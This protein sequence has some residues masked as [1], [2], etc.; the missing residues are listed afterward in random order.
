MVSHLIAV[1]IVS[2]AATLA[3]FLLQRLFANRVPGYAFPVA[4]GLTAISYNLWAEYTWYARTKAAL[5]DTVEVVQTYQVSSALTP[6]TVLMP[7]IDRFAAIDRGRTQTNPGLPDFRLAPVLLVERFAPT[8]QVMRVFD[9]AAQT[10]AEVS[11]A[12]QFAEDGRLTDISWTNDPEFKPMLDVVCRQS[13][14]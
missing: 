6:W 4:I 13:A 14:P 9:C 8:I 7:R 2:A 12:A 10:S 1:L 5:P 11:A 3:V